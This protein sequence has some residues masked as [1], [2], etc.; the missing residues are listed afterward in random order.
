MVKPS[1][2]LGHEDQALCFQTD[3]ETQTPMC[4]DVHDFSG[5]QSD[6]ELDLTSLARFSLIKVQTY[7]LVSNELKCRF[8]IAKKKKE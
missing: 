4:S 5:V 2:F 7:I 3:K 6:L 1:L 8:E